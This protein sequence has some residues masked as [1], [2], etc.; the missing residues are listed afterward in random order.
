MLYHIGYNTTLQN[1]TTLF[2]SVAVGHE[3]SMNHRLHIELVSVRMDLISRFLIFQV[4]CDLENF[5]LEHDAAINNNNH[6]LLSTPTQ[7]SAQQN[8]HHQP[9]EGP[10]G[11]KAQLVQDGQ[12]NK[13]PH[14][15]NENY[16]TLSKHVTI[17]IF[18][19]S[20]ES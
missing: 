14:E 3:Y 11:P 16:V 5:L 9:P 19:L 17:L 8:A 4:W 7:Q 20:K 13:I 1:H 2:L 10:E 15:P 6:Q 12:Q 18:K